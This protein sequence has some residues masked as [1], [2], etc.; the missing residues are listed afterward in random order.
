MKLEVVA[1]SNLYNLQ[2]QLANDEIQIT[3]AQSDERLAR[4]TLGQLHNW[5]SDRSFELESVS[6]SN[7]NSMDNPGESG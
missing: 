7:Q 5:P 2:A 6:T 4:M 1:E 3:G